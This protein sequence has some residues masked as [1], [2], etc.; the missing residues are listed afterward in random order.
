MGRKFL[1]PFLKRIHGTILFVMYVNIK[2]LR[3]IEHVECTVF[4]QICAVFIVQIS[5]NNKKFCK[6]SGI[7]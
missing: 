6:K 1:T 2:N 3:D 7:L 4:M 5:T